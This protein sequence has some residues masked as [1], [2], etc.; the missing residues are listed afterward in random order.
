V[1]EVVDSLGDWRWR[2]A[3]LYWIVD[4]YGKKVRFVPN[5]E[6]LDLLSNLHYMNLVLKARQLGF[7]T[8]IDILGLDQTLFTPDYTA[9]IIAHGLREAD[10]IF[11]NKV[12]Y[13]WDKLPDGVKALNPP[14]N[15]TASEFVFSNGSSISVTASARSGTLQF[16][17]ISEYGKICRRFPDKAGEIKTGSFPSV[18]AGGLVFVESTAEGTG[19]HF[20]EMVKEAEKRGDR[21]PNDMEFKLHF[22]PWWKKESY[23]LEPDGVIDEPEVID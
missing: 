6:Q 12:K 15:Q 7:T 16:L 22:Y 10:K 21:P 23:R 19:G 8:L 20:Y 14:V 11:R 3:N 17:H 2:L 1:I 13:P 18:H 9:A 5:A 4:E